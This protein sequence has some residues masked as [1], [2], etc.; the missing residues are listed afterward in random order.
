MVFDPYSICYTAP[1]VLYYTSYSRRI[2]GRR[3]SSG[4]FAGAGVRDVGQAAK[5]SVTAAVV[6]A[7][8]VVCKSRLSVKELH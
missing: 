8:T 4:P 7:C 2:F 5:D 1:A 6:A 3:V